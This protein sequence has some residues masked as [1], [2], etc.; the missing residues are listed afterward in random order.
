MIQ[1]N[2]SLLNK[3]LQVFY[4]YIEFNKEF[5]TKKIHVGPYK[6]INAIFKNNFKSKKSSNKNILL[7]VEKFLK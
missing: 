4:Q 6:T 7:W 3:D 2:I 1:K 5:K